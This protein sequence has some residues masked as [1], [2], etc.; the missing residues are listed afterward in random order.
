MVIGALLFA[1]AAAAGP[2]RDAAVGGDAFCL[3][4]AV[5]RL[6]CPGFGVEPPAGA[7]ERVA[8]RATA[9]CALRVGGEMVCW[10]K[11]DVP[12]PLPGRFTA[13]DVDRSGA[14]ALDAS[15]AI[16][17]T[18]GLPTLDEPPYRAVRVD[19]DTV[20]GLRSDGEADCR[21]PRARLAVPGGPFTSLDF[22]SRGPCGL[23]TDGRVDCWAGR[24]HWRDQGW[25]GP[26][27]WARALSG[28][29]AVALDGE[30]A[31][32]P[33]TP[34]A[35]LRGLGPL[36]DVRGARSGRDGFV[37]WLADGRMAFRA[38]GSPSLA[39]PLASVL[40]GSYYEY[41]G[42]RV[43]GGIGCVE[44]QGVTVIQGAERYV[45][46]DARG[47]ATTSSGARVQIGPPRGTDDGGWRQPPRSHGGCGLLRDG[48]IRCENLA[49]CGRQWRPA[50]LPAPPPDRFEVVGSGSSFACGLRSDGRVRCWGAAG[51]VPEGKFVRLGVAEKTACGLRATGRIE[52]W[53][54]TGSWFRPPS[55][56]RYTDLDGQ[57]GSFCALR[58]DGVVACWGG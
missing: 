4:D 17:C 20:C 30:L 10:G 16:R 38:P 39:G 32:L 13:L 22:G 31:G 56:G 37:A 5:G 46:L 34:G 40:V 35:E 47:V 48:T 45:A 51:A 19:G 14:C 50:C 15:G 49:E 29:W 6:V 28:D 26:A 21:T 1:A 33:G 36:R 11:S 2:W 42:V 41:C 53:G 43:D 7:F 24:E 25:P 18:A 44:Q 12:T 54:E 57:G 55:A 9:F 52:C 58:A 27:V 8:G 23:R 3:I